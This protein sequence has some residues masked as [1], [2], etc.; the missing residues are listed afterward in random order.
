MEYTTKNEDN[1]KE[2]RYTISRNP[3]TGE[4]LGKYPINTRE[5]IFEAI[6]HAKSV[7][8][9]WRK[10]SLQE[11][12]NKIKRI[13]D[14]LV[15]N[16]ELISEE[17]S[18]ENGKPKMDALATEVLP[19]TIAVDYY[20]KMAKKFLKEEKIRTGNI[21]LFNKRS[22]IVKSPYGVVG[23]ISP[24]NYPFAIPFS[25]I[26]EALLAGNAVIL[27][28]ASISQ[29]VGHRIK[30]CIEAANLPEG[31]FT[32]INIP[33]KY[34]GDYLIDGG[35]DKLFFTGSVETGKYLMKKASE[36]LLPLSLELGG[37]DPMIILKDA[38]IE[39]AA[40]GTVWAGFQNAGQSCGGIERVYVAEEIYDA[41]L[42]KL[43]QYLE[44]LRVGP[45]ILS[46]DF[47]IISESA[48]NTADITD[49]AGLTKQEQ[50]DT[51][52]E[53][54]DDALKKGAT[55]YY[56]Y[57]L[58][59]EYKNY[60]LLYPPTVI[61]N[62]DHSMKLMQDETFGP[63]VGVTPFKNIE[64]AIKLANDSYL[65]LT[66]SVWTKNRKLASKI[67]RNLDVGVVTI[68]DHLMSHG[69]AETP[70]GG[71]KQS[72]IGKTHGEMGFKEMLKY[73][74]VVDDI[75]SFAKRD[76]WWHPYSEQLYLGLQRALTALY[77][78]GIFTKLGSWIKIM[79]VFFRIFHTY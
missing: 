35:I 53:H 22:K 1:N 72:G 78:R 38:D 25:E 37:N 55:I 52:K 12:I 61:T 14:Y 75:L 67:A 2:R 19:T 49:I 34:A 56:Q 13:R 11:R 3:Y 70:W 50:Y 58:K 9:N 6:R 30:T 36:H 46:K 54:I 65:G 45:T 23:I 79:K 68:N 74:V 62:V 20:C 18:K 8:K 27:K 57:S 42:K 28:T 16:A 63:V 41:Y 40:W 29:L 5:E 47:T 64:E 60:P 24:W 77:G 43:K 10:T 21:L 48:I 73:K 44:K 71:F 39:R 33:G 7:Q 4:V 32:L 59:P 66:A 31:V 51:V 76:L 69:L 26:V 17:I 15:Q